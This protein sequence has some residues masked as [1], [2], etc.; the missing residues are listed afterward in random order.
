MAQ[1]NGWE[2]GGGGGGG[3]TACK[4]FPSE[5]EPNTL[6]AT[7]DDHSQWLSVLIFII[8][9]TASC[10]RTCLHLAPC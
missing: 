9:R 4:K 6:S 2:R 3:S 1:S 10:G 5:S 7:S 8:A